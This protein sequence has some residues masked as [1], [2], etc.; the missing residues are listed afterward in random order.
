[1]ESERERGRELEIEKE[2]EGESYSKRDGEKVARERGREMECKGGG[3]RAR[4]GDRGRGFSKRESK[5]GETEMIVLKLE[6][7]RRER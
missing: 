7:A 2:R 3:E 4:G 1:M 6:R 5:R